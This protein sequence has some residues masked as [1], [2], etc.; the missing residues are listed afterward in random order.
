MT[1]PLTLNDLDRSITF[2]DGMT[3]AEII[4]MGG[5]EEDAIIAPVTTALA[6]YE[7][8]RT[9]ETQAAF[10]EALAC[11]RNSDQYPFG[12]YLVP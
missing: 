11:W 10:E 1:A 5:H 3:L 2:M 12:K 8:N 9:V 4:W 6:A 7:K